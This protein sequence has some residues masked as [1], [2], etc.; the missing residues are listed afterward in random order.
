MFVLPLTV[1][2]EDLSYLLGRKHQ[3][4]KVCVKLCGTNVYRVRTGELA[5][6][7]ECN[8]VFS[9]NDVRHA[10]TVIGYL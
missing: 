3:L 2:K 8:E 1:R 6:D 7:V 10:I 4:A 5:G 9:N